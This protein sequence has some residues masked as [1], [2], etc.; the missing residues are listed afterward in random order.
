MSDLGLPEDQPKVVFSDA[1]ILVLEKPAG[2]LS[3]ADGYD[4]TL[5]HLSTILLPT[6]GKIWMVHRLDR[7]TSG[8]M[9]VARNPES[10]RILNQQFRDHLVSKS[11]HAVVEPVPDWVEINLDA[12]LRVDADREHRT[13]VDFSRGK[14]AQTN[15][16]VL[17]SN[18]DFALLECQILTG[19]RHQIRAHLYSIGLN[20]MGDELYQ[21]HKSVRS[22]KATRMLL[23]ASKL[24]FNH[25][26]SDEALHFES[27][28]PIE[29]SSFI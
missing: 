2:V 17:K 10:H 12:P 4:Q 7:E 27:P 5:L 13:R 28:D 9:V 3:I 6:W 16:C 29:F 18:R 14:P 21:P 8:L 11:Y 19:Y 15:L 1:D 20:I 23:H 26:L 25:P 22:P 24:G